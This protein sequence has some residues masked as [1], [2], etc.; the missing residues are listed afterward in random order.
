MLSNAYFLEN[1][2]F[3]TAE[4]EP[5]KNLHNFRKCIFRKCIF[6]KAF[7][8]KI[9][10]CPPPS[11]EHRDDAHDDGEVDQPLLHREAERVDGALENLGSA[12]G[13]G[14][15]SRDKDDERFLF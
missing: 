2:R 10:S 13:S 14:R 3:D 7:F 9:N 15:P 6:F 4:N 1:F 11:N 12:A 5:A 8:S